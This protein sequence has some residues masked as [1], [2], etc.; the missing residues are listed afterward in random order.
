MRLCRE[1]VGRG[2]VGREWRRAMG[3]G[4]WGWRQ[5]FSQ[6]LRWDYRDYGKEA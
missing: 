3:D 5:G 4:E 6:H 2:W 1:G